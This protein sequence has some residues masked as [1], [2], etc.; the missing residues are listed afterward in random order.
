MTGRIINLRLSAPFDTRLAAPAG[1]ELM[2]TEGCQVSSLSG[3]QTG[4][5]P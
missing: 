3:R 1:Q 2:V 5:E 4:V